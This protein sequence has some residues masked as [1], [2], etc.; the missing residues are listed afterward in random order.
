M[1]LGD[2]PRGA[3][4]MEKEPETIEVEVVEIDGVV[5]AAV[6]PHQQETGGNSRRNWGEWQNWQ[7][8]VRTLNMRWW[9]LWALLGIIAFL[10]LITFGFVIGIIY[11]IYRCIRGILSAIAGVFK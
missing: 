3:I 11:V 5:P 8:R 10:L 4:T 9:P 1:V 6:P 7:G 2:P